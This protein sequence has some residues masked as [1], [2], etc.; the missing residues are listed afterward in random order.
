MQKMMNN[1]GNNAGTITAPPSQSNPQGGQPDKR[2]LRGRFNAAFDNISRQYKFWCW[3]CGVNLSHDGCNCKT[4]KTGHINE[5]TMANPQGGNTAKDA[6][7]MKWIDPKSG[8][9]VDQCVFV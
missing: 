2:T 5:A 8:R 9:T 3:S 6:R 7:F 1:I 4:R